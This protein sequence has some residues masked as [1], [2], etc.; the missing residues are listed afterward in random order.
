M[1]RYATLPVQLIVLEYRCEDCGPEDIHTQPLA[2]ITYSGTLICPEC[3]NDMD[4]TEN[5]RVL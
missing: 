1:A 5:V 2:D 4:L 3:G